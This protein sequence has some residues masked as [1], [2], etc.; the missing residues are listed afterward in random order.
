[1]YSCS[2][3]LNGHA[4]AGAA[5]A[6]CADL[7]QPRR[8]AGGQG[9]TSCSPTVLAKTTTSFLTRRH[10]C[11]HG[12]NASY[13]NRC[14]DARLRLA[15]GGRPTV[16]IY[17]Y[18][19]RE[20]TVL[21]AVILAV[22]ALR[23][24]REEPGGNYAIFVSHHTL[25][26]AVTEVVWTLTI[27]QASKLKVASGEHLAAI[28]TTAFL[29]TSPTSIDMAGEPDLVFKLGSAALTKVT[30]SRLGCGHASFADFEV[31]SLPGK[32]REF[33]A[34][35][36]RAQDAGKEPDQRVSSNLHLSQC[37]PPP[38]R[39]GRDTRSQEPT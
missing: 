4:R 7:L 38:R 25:S 28:L 30:S 16:C 32:F 39:T 35:I 37:R 15:V 1:M 5:T 23:D 27:E 33:D 9:R 29:Y 34:A 2:Y 11:E 8:L 10:R 26:W 31:K 24:A 3:V 13:G 36:N 12:L 18:L 19:E 22:L 17:V 14:R 6:G 21:A 20:Y